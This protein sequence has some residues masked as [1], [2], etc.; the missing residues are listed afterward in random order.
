MSFD[1]NDLWASLNNHR[2]CQ[3]SAE[4]NDLWTLLCDKKGFKSLDFACGV[5][6]DRYVVIDV[7][8]GGRN[9]ENDGDDESDEGF[10]FLVGNQVR[11]ATMYDVVTKS[12]ITL[13]NPLS[14]QSCRG[15]VLNGHF[16]VI[17]YRHGM[18]RIRLNKPKHWEH[19]VID[20]NLFVDDLQSTV[21]VGNH[22]F[23]I[24]A[25]SF[26]HRYTP[27]INKHTT[28][29]PNINARPRL[30]FATAVVDTEIFIIGG[31]NSECTVNNVDVFDV[32]TN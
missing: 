25:G 5:Y 13:P 14:F 32:I 7:G 4:D 2:C 22:M 28:M 29:K 27:F 9:I 11:Y 12:H 31:D 16:Y 8:R 21:A 20:N 3:R 30:E 1:V 18:Y 6:S 24:E 19:L 10:A 15:V 23:F 17:K 26:I